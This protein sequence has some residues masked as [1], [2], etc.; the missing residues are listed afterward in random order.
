MKYNTANDA[1]ATAAAEYLVTLIDKKQ[2]AEVIKVSPKRTLNQNS[3]LHLIIGAYGANFGY[4]LAE[5]KTLYKRDVNPDIY[6]YKRHGSMF[7]RSSADLTKEEMAKSID[8]FM[9]MSAEQGFPLPLATDQE[10][11]RQIENEIER[12]RHFL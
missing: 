4:T 12:S 5:A 9:Q 6:V 11:L 3:Y 8:R 10:W 2:I 7:L 1:E